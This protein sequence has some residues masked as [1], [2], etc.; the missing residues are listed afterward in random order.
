M[1]TNIIHDRKSQKRGDDAEDRF[2]AACKAKWGQAP[3]KSTRSE[4]IIEHWDFK[5]ANGDRVEVKAAK[6]RKRGQ[7][8]DLSIIFVELVG[9]TGHKGWLYGMAD[10]I[11][12]ELADCF[13]L[14]KRGDLIQ[15]ITDKVIDEWVPTP[16]LY[17]LYRRKDRPQEKVTLVSTNDVLGLWHVKLPKV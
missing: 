14:V 2:V 8:T 16:T 3:I 9:I 5:T 13:V 1:H 7:G 6:Q 15:L 10:K 12:F 17:K 4:D 11:A